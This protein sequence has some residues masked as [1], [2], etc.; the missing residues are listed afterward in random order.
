ME[1]KSAWTG[2]QSW[3]SQ[4]GTVGEIRGHIVTPGGKGRTDPEEVQKVRGC[5][6]HVGGALLGIADG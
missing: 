4:P 1:R 2:G 3:I 5:R 6:L